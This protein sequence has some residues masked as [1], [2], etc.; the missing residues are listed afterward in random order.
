MYRTHRTSPASKILWRS[1][2]ACV[3]AAVCTSCSGGGGSSDSPAAGGSAGGAG[4]S[5]SGSGNGSGSPAAGSAADVLTY[6]NDIGRTG[7]YLAETTL[8]PANVNAAHFG[9]VAFLAADG[10]VDAQPLYAGNVSIN[11]ATHNVVYVATEHASVYAFDADTN[12]KLWQRSLLGSGETTSD[13]H[14]CSQITPEIGITSTPVIDRSRGAN[15]VLY[16]VAMSKDANGAYHQRLHALDLSTGAELLG[17]PKEIA[18][19]YP[20]TGA[21][22]SNGTVTFDPKQY[23]ERQALTLLSGNVYL[24]WTSHCDQQPYS[25]WVM[26]YSA[27]TLA[28]TSVL[29]V[30][31]NGSEGSV[32][33]SGAGMASDGASLYLL[34]AN[35]TFDTALNDNGFPSNGDYGNTFLKLAVSPKLGVADYFA[36]FD[37]VAQSN[38]D[39]DLGSG[40]ALVLPD[41]VDAGGA[42][43]HLAVGAGKDSKIYVV[44]RDAM[45]KFNATRNAIWQEIDGQLGG[46]VF[47]MPAYYGGVVYYGAVGDSLKAFPL[48]AAKLATTPSS[49]SAGTFA[50]P[51][52]TPSVSANGT[53]NAIVWA[54][55]NGSVGALHAFNAGNLAQELYSSRQSGTRDSFGAGNKFITPMI[56][57]GHVYVGATNGVAV[58]G[59]L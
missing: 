53:Q 5:G 34:D 30:T 44:D 16:A 29:N 52:T 2:A 11:G 49:K 59:L 35:G 51:G 24:A 26:A 55:E 22:S 4:G 18:A 58:F 19:T 12:T 20:G 41:L 37:T 15:G 57:H 31:P 17:G 42:T 47:G 46:G 25:G 14:S 28:Q 48:T 6:H 7:Q 45:G 56:A 21:N 1:L 36:T 3:V 27:D 9:K 43:R 39:Q 8:T 50:Y 10:K 33:M 23:A 13:S 32:W 38:R 54:A 40:G